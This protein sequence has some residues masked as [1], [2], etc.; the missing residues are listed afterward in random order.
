MSSPSNASCARRAKRCRS[1]TSR[2]PSGLEESRLQCVGRGGRRRR[3]ALVLVGATIVAAVALGVTAGSLNAPTGTAAREPAV[4]GLRP[5]ARLVRAPIPTAR[6][7]RS[8][9]GRRCRQHPVLFATTTI[10][11]LREPSG[12]P[13]LDAPESAVEGHRRWYA[14]MNAGCG[15][16]S[17]AATLANAM[18]PRGRA[19]T[20]GSVTVCHS[21]PVGRGGAARPAA[22]PVPA[23][24]ADTGATTSTSLPTSGRLASDGGWSWMRLNGSST[25]SSSGPRATRSARRT[26]SFLFGPAP[27]RSPSSTARTRARTTFLGGLY[28]LKNTCACGHSVRRLGAG[29]KLPYVV[30]GQREDGQNPGDWFADAQPSYSLAWITAGIPYRARHDR[31]RQRGGV[32]LGTR[33]GG[34]IGDRTHRSVARHP[35]R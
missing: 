2:P 13:L 20:P 12:L 25:G 11:G 1:R 15:A 33:G 4:L 14:S 28:E 22:R 26:L 34:T 24:C 30:A 10:H 9:D 29:L 3:A 31:R 17:V 18:Y 16:G 23:A 27:R 32:L 35:A 19:S 6:N 7:P 5:R 21:C 8:A